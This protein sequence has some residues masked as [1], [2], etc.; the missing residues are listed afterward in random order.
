MEIKMK[1]KQNNSL[2]RSRALSNVLVTLASVIVINSFSISTALAEENSESEITQEQIIKYNEIS[3]SAKQNKVQQAAKGDATGND[4][5]VF[6]NKFMPFYRSTEL[7]NGMIQQDLTAMGTIRFSDRVGMFYEAPVAQYR[8]LSDVDGL[9]EVEDKIGMGDIDLKFLWRPEATDFAFGEG[10][11]KSGSLLFGNS[12]VLPTGSDGLTGN[13]L[14]FAPIVGIVVD[15]PLHGF[16]AM[17]NLYYLDVYKEADAPDTSRF[18][19]RWFYMQPLSK[20]GPWYGGLYA[21][22]EFQPVYDFETDEFSTWLGLEFGKMFA[23]GR[24]GYIKPGWGT[25]GS[26]LTDRDVTFEA[27]FR[28]F[29]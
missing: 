5:R 12:F 29:F 17:L 10:D 7:E 4:P 14:L 19:G 20:P 13:T 22:P 24:I 6:S 21:M 9:S 16:F 8:D 15:M 27:G 1:N 11:K 2:S 23:P 26:E 28:W 25:S 18:V 3:A